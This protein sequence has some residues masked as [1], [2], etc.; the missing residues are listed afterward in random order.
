MSSCFFGHAVRIN[1]LL[2]S[3]N[4]FFLTGNKIQ[5]IVI[6]YNSFSVYLPL[7][8]ITIE[9]PLPD[10]WIKNCLFW[11]RFIRASDSPF[12]RCWD[13]LLLWVR[14]EY[15]PISL[16]FVIINRSNHPEVFYKKGIEI[17]QNSQENTCDTVSVLIKLSPA[18]LLK[19]RFW[20]MC[21]PVNFAKFP[22]TLFLQNTSAGCLCIKSKSS[23]ERT[24]IIQNWQGNQHD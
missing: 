12:D 6:F 4:A 9:L 15:S 21:F 8:T 2:E 23:A 19:K 13:T 11:D 24:K 3:I 16:D 17:S 7:S 5:E 18:T 14:K 22:R 1:K 20:H 10:F